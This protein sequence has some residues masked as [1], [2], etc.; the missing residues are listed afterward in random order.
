MVWFEKLERHDE[1]RVPV[2]AAEVHEAPAREQ[3]DA[4]AV[5][6]DELVDLRLD[7]HFLDLGVLLEP[8]DVD[9]AVEVADVAE[10]GLVLHR[11]HVLARG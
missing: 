3:R 7:V 5:G 8:G 6:E 4:L 2:R 1:R 11:A 10:D 9:L